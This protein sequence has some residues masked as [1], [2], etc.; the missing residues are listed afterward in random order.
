MK[1][2]SIFCVVLVFIFIL[3]GCVNTPKVDP[4]SE[5]QLTENN[6]NQTEDVLEAMVNQKGS[7]SDKTVLGVVKLV[8]MMDGDVMMNMID[9]FSPLITFF[10]NYATIQQPELQMPTVFSNG[11]KV[12]SFINAVNG[13]DID[14]SSIQQ[15]LIAVSLSLKA[16]NN[17]LNSIIDLSEIEGFTE[18]NIYP[19]QFDWD[20]DGTV[21]PTEELKVFVRYKDT[22]DEIQE[23]D[24]GIFNGII[25]E[26]FPA[27]IKEFI[28]VGISENGGD[29]IYPTYNATTD[30][31]EFDES[32]VI[33]FYDIQ[34]LIEIALSTNSI[35]AI[36]DML[37]V[38]DF[39][40]E[41]LFDL[42]YDLITGVISGDDTLQQIID[43]IDT[44][45]DGNLSRSEII[46]FLGNNYLTFLSG[47]EQRLKDIE[48]LV[49]DK[50][51]TLLT[52][53]DDAPQDILDEID[54]WRPYFNN[55]VYDTG[56]LFPGMQENL[57]L[58]FYKIFENSQNFSDL[59]DFIPDIEITVLS[60]EIVNY[61]LSF[62]DPTFGGFVE[63]FPSVFPP[64]F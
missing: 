58:Y 51:Y 24:L 23:V 60:G 45:G 30:T 31:Y 29:G 26:D 35:E 12:L 56:E 7:D 15:S 28:N 8:K 43:E 42:I 48:P 22:S 17:Y 52:K 38:Y 37:T 6:L 33:S 1:R 36:L 49:F 13:L 27:D 44:D 63:N 59:K 54:E 61:S 47:G 5:V 55:Q 39:E 20:N 62:P 50:I 53:I 3:S 21:E 34:M 41:K 11:V 32:S 9:S 16:I 40:S 46:T 10:L 25:G 18:L 57:K 64:V 14:I 2:I 19:N 4:I